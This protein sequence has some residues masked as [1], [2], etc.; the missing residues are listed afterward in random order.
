MAALSSMALAANSDTITV[1]YEVQAINE[2]AITDAAVTL[3]VSAATAGSQP[4][5][6]TASTT[7]DITTNETKKITAVLDTAMPAN[8]TLTL[9][10]AAPTGGTSAGAVTLT[11]VAADVVTGISEV[12]EAGK[13]LTFGLSATVSAGVVAA[14]SKTCTLTVTN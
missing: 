14:A 9:N 5:A 6:V 12:A 1:N 11:N 8:T 4:N 10:A 2:L 3:T 7:Y 13:S